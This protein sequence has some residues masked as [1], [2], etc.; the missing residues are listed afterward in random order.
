MAARTAPSAAS[1]LSLRATFLISEG[2]KVAG[3]GCREPVL[4]VDGP[5]PG[6]GAGV[7]GEGHVTIP[8][9]IR[10]RLGFLPGIGA[11]EEGGSGGVSGVVR[12]AA[13]QAV[14]LVRASARGASQAE[15]RPFDRISHS[16]VSEARRASGRGTFPMKRAPKAEQPEGRGRFVVRPGGGGHDSA[17]GLP[18]SV[19]TFTNLAHGE[20]KPERLPDEHDRRDSQRDRRPN[21]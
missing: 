16:T 6:Q 8:Q 15:L 14:G 13:L 18:E 1:S 4:P 3:I 7:S 2:V 17:L 11:E 20:S 21:C 9:R 12:S 5:A 19:S 10:E